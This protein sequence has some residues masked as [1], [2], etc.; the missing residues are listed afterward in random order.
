MG[1]VEVA[2]GRRAAPNAPLLDTA[3][4]RRRMC[5]QLLHQDLDEISG[6]ALLEQ[7]CDI[8]FQRRLVALDGEI[9]A[10]STLAPIV[11]LLLDQIGG[12]FA[13]CFQL[14]HQLGQQGIDA[15]VLAC[16]VDGFKQRNRHADFE[17]AFNSCAI[18]AL[19]FITARYRQCAYY[20]CA[21]VPTFFWAWQRFD[22]CPITL[23]MCA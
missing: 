19:L 20:S 15:D 5:F 9:N 18:G 11:R 14:L 23:M 17:C 1:E 13:M 7:Q 10:L 22:L 21:K 4:I 12:E 3:M 8:S 16:D 2:I 6:A